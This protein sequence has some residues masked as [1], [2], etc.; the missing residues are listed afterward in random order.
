M[1]GRSAESLMEEIKNLR[2]DTP[3][4]RLAYLRMGI[5]FAENDPPEASML[6]PHVAGGLIKINL[7]LGQGVDGPFFVCQ[8]IKRP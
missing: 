8:T 3:D 2:P 5:Y 6:H 7:S 4:Y 1:Q